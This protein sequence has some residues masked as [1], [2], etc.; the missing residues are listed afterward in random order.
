MIIKPRSES[1][2]LKMMRAL[3]ARMSF[4]A[5]EETYYLNLEKG[6]IG[7][8]VFDKRLDDLSHERLILNDLLLEYNHTLFQIDSL[9]ITSNT[10]YLFEVKNYEGDFYIEADRWYSLSKN[11]I[12]NPLLQLQRNESLFRRLLQDLGFTLPIESYLIF[13][14]PEFQ[15]YLAPQN[16]PIIFPTQLNRFISKLNKIPSKLKDT[17][18]KLAEHL[19]SLHLDES[20]YNRLPEY[21]YSKLKKGIACPNCHKLFDT[22]IKKVLICHGCGFNEEFYPAVLRS[23]E[24]FR[25]LFPSSRITTNYIYEWCDIIKTKKTIRKL[26]SRNFKQIGYGKIS[27]YSDKD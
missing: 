18:S 1:L 22:F 15:L 12:K 17:H 9:L 7:E 23:I 16:L 11:E 20:P 5:K 24:E 4:S 14:N 13:V 26:L 8:K 21:H 25:T 3:Y 10:I 19:L 6:Y 2:E 27:Y